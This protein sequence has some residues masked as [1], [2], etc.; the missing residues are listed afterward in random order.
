MKYTFESLQRLGA[1]AI[2]L[3]CCDPHFAIDDSGPI[4]AMNMKK[5]L[6]KHDLFPICLTPDNCKYPINIGSSNPV[7]RNRSVNY[8]KK[9]IQFANEFECPTVQFFAGFPTLDENYEDGWKRSVESLSILADVAE[10][11]GVQI[12]IEAADRILTVLYNTKKIHDMIIDVNSPNLFGMI[13]I[14][15]L[16]QTHETI[17]EAIAN[18]TPEFVKHCHFSDAMADGSSIDHIV[19]GEGTFDLDHVLD[20][21]D[22]IGYKGYFSLE[23]MSPYEK[24]AEEVMSRGAA[25]MRAHFA[26]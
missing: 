16:V 25:W 2:E 12:T 6:K 22:K 24:V 1:H 7:C 5:E 9:V 15:C 17:D 26:D 18:I 21:F 23:L 4:E 10:A 13:D 8:Y 14:A 20:A 19:P 3:Y 11:Y